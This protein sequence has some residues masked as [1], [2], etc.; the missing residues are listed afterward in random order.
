MVLTGRKFGYNDSFQQQ[1]FWCLSTGKKLEN[2]LRYQ[3]GQLNVNRP[4]L[5]DSFQFEQHTYKYIC[6]TF[7]SVLCPFMSR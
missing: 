3:K 5:I 4:N 2:V 7:F 1:W 6:S